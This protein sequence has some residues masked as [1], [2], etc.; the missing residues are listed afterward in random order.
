MT[1]AVTWPQLVFVAA[2]IVGSISITIG[3]LIWLWNK[4]E[5]MDRHRADEQDDLKEALLLQLRETRH[6]LFGRIDMMNAKH[7][8]DIDDMRK[9]F[10]DTGSAIRQKINEVELWTRDHFVPNNHFD[11]IIK[12]HDKQNDMLV[13]KFDSGMQRLEGKIDRLQATG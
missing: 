5:K 4:L 8:D 13:A 10:G 6:T 2:V 9:S 3:V 12:M 7:D 11:Q 1:G